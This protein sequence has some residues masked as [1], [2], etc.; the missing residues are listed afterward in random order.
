MEIGC[1]EG[2]VLKAFVENDSYCLGVELSQGRVDV[3]NKFQKDA[4]AQ[5]KIK[6]ISKDIYDFDLNDSEKF[7]LVILKDV[8]EHIH[9]QAKFMKKIHEFLNKDAYIFFG[10]PSWRMPYGGHQQV[11]KSKIASKLP[12]FH[13]LPRGIYKFILQAFGEDKQKIENL[14]EI[15]DTRISTARFEKI[16]KANNF[17]INKRIKYFI[18]P[19]YEYKFGYKTKLLWNWVAAIPWFNDFF[20]FQ[21][22]YLISNKK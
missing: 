11:C 2:G 16:C 9:D 20:T 19:I 12:Y 13:I 17:K 5:G 3:A 1:A 15:K 7:D 21:S 4:V 6:F 18:A 10:F 14:L 8:I 22:Y